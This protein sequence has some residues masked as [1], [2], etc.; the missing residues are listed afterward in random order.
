MPRWY[1][2]G[3]VD[4]VPPQLPRVRSGGGAELLE[5]MLT[6]MGGIGHNDTYTAVE[7]V[8]RYDFGLAS[9]AL[10]PNHALT[11]SDLS[12]S[13]VVA[14]VMYV[15]EWLSLFAYDPVAATITKIGTPPAT[16]SNGLVTYYNNLFYLFGGFA[17]GRVYTFDGVS[18]WNTLADPPS[19]LNWA[20]QV[21]VGDAIW[22]LGGEDA[23]E[24]PQ[25]YAQ[26]FDLATHT[27]S[28]GPALPLGRSRGRAVVWDNKVWLIGGRVRDGV[29]YLDDERVHVYDLTTNTWDLGPALPTGAGRETPA[30]LATVDG[31]YV[32]GGFH[33]G[34]YVGVD[35]VDFYGTPPGAATLI[36][37]TLGGSYH[38]TTPVLTGEYACWLPPEANLMG[39]YDVP[40][41]GITRA[42]LTGEY[43]T[44]RETSAILTGRYDSLDTETLPARADLKVW[45]T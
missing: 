33:S 13:V 18:T 17:S 41:T 42:T 15:Q 12:S 20:Q 24:V 16:V 43:W 6:L 25:T 11:D 4:W 5:G 10:G 23:S 21:R 44:S 45:V 1:S 31:I 2:R 8:D 9:W 26:I 14:G 34:S 19:P 39:S 35:W 40:D 30:L 38:T 22:R 3:D 29:T 28:T 37:A 7:P 27:W 36:E 32:L